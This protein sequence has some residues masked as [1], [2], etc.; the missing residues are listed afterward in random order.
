MFKS[1]Y[2]MFKLYSPTPLSRFT[3]KELRTIAI[4]CQEY[5]ETNMGIN[6]RHKTPLKIRLVKNPYSD[7][8]HGD[9]CPHENTVRLFHDEIKNLGEFTS[10]FIHE[11][12][13][14]LQPIKTKYTKLM[15]QYGY[16][17]HPHEIEA[18]NNETLHNRKALT[19]IRKRLK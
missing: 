4:T 19:Y 14:S 3:K 1:L 13:H 10:A 5:C 12:T 2:N 15:K 7:I 11:Y 8:C 9:Y 6:K 16:H 17:K 18:Y